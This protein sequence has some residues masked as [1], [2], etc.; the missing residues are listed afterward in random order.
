MEARTALCAVLLTYFGQENGD[1][2][3]CRTSR[4]R[5]K[6]YPERVLD[7][8]AVSRSSRRPNNE[9]SGRARRS[10][11]CRERRGRTR[12]YRT[13]AQLINRHCYLTSKPKCAFLQGREG[14]GFRWRKQGDC[15]LVLGAEL[16]F[17][18]DSSGPYKGPLGDRARRG[19]SESKIIT[20]LGGSLREIGD[21]WRVTKEAM[22]GVVA[23]SWLG[24]GL[25]TEGA[26]PQVPQRPIFWR[27]MMRLLTHENPNRCWARWSAESV[28]PRTQLLWCSCRRRRA[29]QDRAGD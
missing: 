11:K 25:V 21:A 27:C 7:M 22:A 16:R 18:G 1:P 6:S 28:S 15:L 23:E 19:L 9:R 14:W 26:R 2:H 13:G 24:R 12:F 3:R 5:R 4:G 20:Q 10:L 17:Y 29:R 8:G